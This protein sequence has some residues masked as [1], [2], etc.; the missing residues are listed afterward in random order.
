MIARAGDRTFVATANPGLLMSVSSARA[1]RG[2]FE[3]DVKDA[4]LVSTWGVVAW[5]ASAPAGTKVEVFTRSGNTKTP[6][7]AWSDW[8][9]SVRQR[10]RLADHQPE[11]ALP[12]VARG[13]DRNRDRGSGADVPVVGLSAAQHPPAGD[14]DHRSSAGRRVPEAVL[15]RRNRDR[16]SRRRRAGQARRGEQRRLGGGAP[17]LG[18]RIYQKGLQTFVWKADDDNGD[19]LSYDVFYRREGDTTWRHA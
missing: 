4:R 5:R 16:R 13:A 8:S 14:V 7:E 10:R 2:T 9:G 12:A 18:R 1:T 19:E 15:E 6:D 17:A 3:S 11:G